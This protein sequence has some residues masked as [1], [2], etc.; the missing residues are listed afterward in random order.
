M[1]R[2]ALGSVVQSVWSRR[3]GRYLHLVL[4]SRDA[5]LV[6][7]VADY[8]APRAVPI[9]DLVIHSRRYHRRSAQDLLLG[10]ALH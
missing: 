9:V 7:A 4:T 6:A 10:H 2:F 3:K 5:A 1:I 8:T